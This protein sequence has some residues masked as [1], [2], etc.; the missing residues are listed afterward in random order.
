MGKHQ[1]RLLK[2]C[3]KYP[4]WHSMGKTREDNR[5]LWR[6]YDMELIE[7]FHHSKNN[8]LQ[9]RLMPPQAKE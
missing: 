8:R 7:I 2:F 4:G 1:L 9:F 3:L 6:L 5:A